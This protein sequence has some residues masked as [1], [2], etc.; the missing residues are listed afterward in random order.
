MPSRRSFLLGSLAVAGVSG[1]A[2]LDGLT[3]SRDR[4]ARSRRVFAAG[5]PAAVLVYVLS[6]EALVG[7]PSRLDDA[8]LGMLGSPARDL[9]VVGRL[10]GRGSTVPLESLVQMKPD[11]VLDVGAVDATHASMAERVRAQTGLRY[12]LL[13]GRLADS[14]ALLRRVGTLL[15]VPARAEQLARTADRLA[16]DVSSSRAR[17]SSTRVYLARGV[18]G[19]ET[20]LRGSINVEVVEF[21]GAQNV[22]AAAGAGSLTRASLEQVLA[23]DPDVIL[24]QDPRFARTALADPVWRTTRA[25]RERRVWCAPTLPFGWLD[26]PPGINRLIGAL[27][28]ARRID[29]AALAAIRDDVRTFYD[30]F[31]RVTLSSADLDRLLAEAA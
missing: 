2:R 9:P 19:L 23:W 28:L 15:D 8:A 10:A 17:R 4:Q 18:D 22:A 11:F 26:G 30:S 31:Y 24:T 14:A 7:W 20:G 5:P 27:W 13:D 12:E 25:A 29:G 21:V 16:S 1:L 6:P 3:Q